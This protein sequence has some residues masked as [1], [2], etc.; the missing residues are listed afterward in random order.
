[1]VMPDGGEINL[2]L[3]PYNFADMK[4]DTPIVVLIP[5]CL[6]NSQIG[7]V[8]EYAKIVEKKGWRLA[9][10]NRRGFDMEPLKSENF[11]HD[12]EMKDFKIVL[13]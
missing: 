13:Q 1:M 11:I 7:Y 8:K 5:G 12:D 3:F 2:D 4:T 9:V 6:G 10:M